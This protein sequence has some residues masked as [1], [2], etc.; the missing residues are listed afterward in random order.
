[1]HHVEV[2]ALLGE[3]APELAG[4]ITAPDL[5]MVLTVRGSDGA[6]IPTLTDPDGVIAYYPQKVIARYSTD[7][8]RV[9][10]VR[11][12]SVW[13][14]PLGDLPATVDSGGLGR[15]LSP[16]GAEYVVTG[17]I[18]GI[19]A[20]VVRLRV[21]AGR[22]DEVERVTVNGR[23]MVSATDLAVPVTAAPPPFV[24]DVDGADVEVVTTPSGRSGRRIIGTL[25]VFAA[26]PIGVGPAGNDVAIL[27][28]LP[29]PAGLVEWW[30]QPVISSVLGSSLWVVL[31]NGAA[32]EW[33]R[34]V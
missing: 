31:H 4:G 24:G 12:R 27:A 2:V 17:R 9:V 34:V 22:L 13:A 10:S 15:C 33:R 29:D 21:D 7:D 6:A 16:E 3:F 25:E 32:L 14:L 8:L 19:K 28:A 18:G 23:P 5:D 26:S 1:M 20:P 11:G 30:R